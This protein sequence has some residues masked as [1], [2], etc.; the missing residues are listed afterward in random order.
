[1]DII[2]F[3]PCAAPRARSGLAR[4][5]SVGFLFALLPAVSRSLWAGSTRGYSIRGRRCVPGADCWARLGSVGFR[6][7]GRSGPGSPA[8]ESFVN[9]D[10]H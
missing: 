4:V 9:K 3:D 5:G 6:C 2:G 7:A 8:A 10:R 1:M